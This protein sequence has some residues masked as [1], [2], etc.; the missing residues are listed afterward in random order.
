MFDQHLHISLVFNDMGS[1]M[2]L[3]TVIRD[4]LTL[5]SLI[6]VD[7]SS[8]NPAISTLRRNN[9][10]DAWQVSREGSDI[11]LAR[12]FAEGFVEGSPKFLVLVLFRR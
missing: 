4:D 9:D 8:K 3:K 7:C 10:S 6:I 1:I 2:P 11:E 5:P 12:D